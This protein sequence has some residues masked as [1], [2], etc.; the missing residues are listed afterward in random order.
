MPNGPKRSDPHGPGPERARG[1]AHH[2]AGP[3][4]KEACEASVHQA[5][6]D[7]PDPLHSARGVRLPQPL[8]LVK[9]RGTKR[10]RRAEG[11]P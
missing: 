2:D 11:G 10:L 7:A 1:A 4:K 6:G 8:P 9:A 5:G 3:N